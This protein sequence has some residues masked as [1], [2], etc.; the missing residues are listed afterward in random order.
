MGRK[1]NRGI[2]PDKSE[3]TNV[4]LRERTT[5]E[6]IVSIQIFLHLGDFSSKGNSVRQG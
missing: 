1:R 5:I 2:G 3:Y 4:K 6:F